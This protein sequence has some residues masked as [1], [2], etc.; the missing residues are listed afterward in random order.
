MSPSAPAA[1]CDSCRFSWNSAG[2]VE[3]LRLLGSCPRCGTG[4]VLFRD[5]EAELTASSGPERESIDEPTDDLV[6]PHLV[7]GLPRR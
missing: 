3:G 2:M 7:L 5:A 1:Q 6:P 4:T